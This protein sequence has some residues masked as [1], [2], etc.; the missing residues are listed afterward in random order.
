MAFARVCKIARGTYND[1]P[2]VLQMASSTFR[3]SA[4]RCLA[5]PNRSSRLATEHGIMKSRVACF[6]HVQQGRYHRLPQWHVPTLGGYRPTKI[7]P[8]PSNWSDLQPWL[9]IFFCDGL[10]DRTVQQIAPS[11]FRRSGALNECS[12]IPIG[13]AVR[14]P[15]A[16]VL[17]QTDKHRPAY[18]FQR[19]T[20]ENFRA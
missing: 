19:P 2:N 13:L 16:Q 6:L 11:S 3:R 5:G 10:R 20:R 12:P 14:A 15:K 8:N 17:G 18:F 9:N 7:E 1:A 4:R